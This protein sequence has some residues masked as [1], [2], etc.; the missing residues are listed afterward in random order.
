MQFEWDSGKA[1]RNLRKHG[2]AFPE[3]VSAFGDPLSETFPD[4][5][6]SEEERRWVTIGQAET[7][8]LLVVAHTDR[9]RKLRIITARPATP[10]ERRYYE[11]KN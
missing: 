5:F 10:R 11:N 2:V 3:A 6:H 7:G 4:P 1:A 9:Q 8:R